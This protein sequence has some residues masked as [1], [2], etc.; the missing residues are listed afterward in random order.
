[1]VHGKGL[2]AHSTNL[3][4]HPRLDDTALGDGKAGDARLGLLGGID[5]A[6]CPASEPEGMIGMG[7]GDDDGGGR[8]RCKYPKP[9][10]AAIDHDARAP[11]FDEKRAMTA[12]TARPE[13]DLAACAEEGNFDLR[14]P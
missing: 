1:V 14:F 10:G 2:Q 3:K 13:L 7:V 6:R 11:P 12:V 5:R 8:D 4:R 9:I